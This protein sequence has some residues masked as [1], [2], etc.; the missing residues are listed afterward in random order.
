MKKPRDTHGA[1]CFAV[2]S[3]REIVV[4]CWK[5]ENHHENDKNHGINPLQF[6]IDDNSTDEAEQNEAHDQCTDVFH[7]ISCW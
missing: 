7:G 2:L 5:W 6:H 1:S 3:R 4:E